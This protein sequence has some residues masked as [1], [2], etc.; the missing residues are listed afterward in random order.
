MPLSDTINT[1]IAE[2]LL[3]QVSLVKD[4]IYARYLKDGEDDQELISFAELFHR[5]S[6]LTVKLQKSIP[7]G[8]RIILVFNSGLEFIIAFWACVLGGFVAVPVNPPRDGT[9]TLRLMALAKDADAYCLLTT[10]H[11]A[12]KINAVDLQDQGFDPKQIFIFDDKLIDVKN[13]EFIIPRINPDDPVFLQYTSGSTG[14]PKG[15]VINHKNVIQNIKMLEHA[16]NMNGKLDLKQE[17]LIGWLPHYHDM[18]LIGCIIF[19]ALSAFTVTMMS[20]LMFLQR[21]IRWLKAISKYRG[22]ISYSP[23]FGYNL[24][25]QKIKEND[26]KE[27]DLSHWEIAV[28]GA[29]P[30]K[31]ETLEK[32]YQKFSVAGF[33]R[34]AFFPA[35]GMAEATLMLTGVDRLSVPNTIKV[36]KDQLLHKGEVRISES[37]TAQTFVSCGKPGVDLDISILNPLTLEELSN[38]KV[39]E[40]CVSGENITQGYWQ[41]EELNNEIYVN[42]RDKRYLKT[43]DLGFIY[44]EELYVTGRLKDVIILRGRNIYPH[45]LEKSTE[46]SHELIKERSVVAFS[47]DDIETEQI[48]VMIEAPS[49][50]DA[51]VKVDIKR[52]ISAK[53]MQDHDV[54]VCIA[55]V[56]KGSILK[57]SSG[58]LQRSAC[59]NLYLNNQ[60]SLIEQQTCNL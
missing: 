20:P 31:A 49:N 38:N 41:H 28:N 9:S 57:T 32:F 25:V 15:V 46:E 43:G 17:H 14:L 4:K 42:I 1:S 39:G 40:I 3:N 37:E 34:E 7:Q 35:Y 21:P 10:Q 27:L 6:A 56:K 44:N 19:P 59:K 45:D 48:V 55:L 16:F 50:L 53:L 47:I 29:E 18:G 52:A 12:D 26:I 24:C 22:T 58:K 54:E 23:N 60:V 51:K 2:V 5:S 8:S 13:H 11:Y 30:V 33:R 36:D